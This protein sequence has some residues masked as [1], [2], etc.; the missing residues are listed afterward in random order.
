[1]HIPINLRSI[2]WK[3]ALIEKI[4]DHLPFLVHSLKIGFLKNEVNRFCKSFA[5]SI[6]INSPGIIIFIYYMFYTI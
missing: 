4:D 2:Q 6:S 5:I 1:V 3:G